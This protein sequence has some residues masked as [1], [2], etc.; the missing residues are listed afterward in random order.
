MKFLY[1]A[2]LLTVMLAAMPLSA[3]RAAPAAISPIEKGGYSYAYQKELSDDR[4]LDAMYVV[5]R[6]TQTGELIWKT[7]LY[8]KHINPALESDVQ[9]IFLKKLSLHGNELAAEDEK[10]SVYRID[11]ATGQLIE[12]KSFN[13]Y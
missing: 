7:M 1:A 3:K 6:S 13:R 10:K 12:P 9:E 8:E 5:C 4:R 2:L 11:L